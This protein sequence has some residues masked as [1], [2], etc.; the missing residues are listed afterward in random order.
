MPSD[1]P[2]G[3]FDVVTWSSAR[4]RAIQ[5]MGSAPVPEAPA[6]AALWAI[7]SGSS[8]AS[9]RLAG[10]PDGPEREL[11]GLLADAEAGRVVDLDRARSLLRARPA[12]PTT[13]AAF[14]RLSRIAGSSVDVDLARTIDDILR[15]SAPD[16]D[17]HV[18]LEGDSRPYIVL[19]LPRWP[20]ASDSRLRAARPFVRGFPT[21]EADRAP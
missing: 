12:A 11:L 18:V 13:I 14:D 4:E 8:T 2:A 17:F 15:A 21:I 10:L 9:E 6:L 7:R 16:P 3:T 5:G 19:A 20:M 1:P